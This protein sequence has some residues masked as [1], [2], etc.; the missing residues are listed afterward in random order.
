MKKPIA[1][2][3]LML[4]LAAGP[5][6]HAA[7]DG[8]MAPSDKTL[9]DLYWRGHESLKKADWQA[10]LE[11]F[12]TLEQEMRKKDPENADAAIYWQAYTL[13]QIKRTTEAR[14][15]VERLHRDFPK[16][17]WGKDADD[18]L[19]QSQAGV[20]VNASASA[21]ASAS[22]D[23]EDITAI[24]V[25]GLMNAPAQRALPLLKK[26]LQSNHSEKVK[27][28]ALFVLSQ[29]DEPTA[30]D[31][32]VDIAK[33]SNDPALR[34]EAVRMLGVSGEDRAVQRLGELYATSKDKSEKRAIIQAWLVA[35]REDLILSTARSEPDP[36]LRR[37]A[38]QTLGAMDAT[39]ALRQLFDADKD[40]ANR[41]AIV[42]AL[43][44]AGA[45]DVLGR[46]AASSEPEEL[47]IEAIRALGV[48]GDHGGTDALVRIY[49][50]ASSPAVRDAAL[51]GLLVAGDSHAVVDLY[52]KA[53]T[54]E[55][56]QALLRVLTTMDSD[57]ALQIIESELNR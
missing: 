36:E 14:A 13:V 5:A 26:V 27:K 12:R 33:S 48:A 11:R 51:Q 7:A 31:A 18:L 40:P 45:T 52:R 10:A 1:C 35:D 50:G 15:A 16:S 37:S 25:E 9:N 44:V 22:A 3:L 8:D 42:Q 38:I 49:A 53:K 57:D 43:G 24:A 4:A 17:R 34:E 41:K 2:A 6:A 55:E 32:L 39:D 56:K 23:D 30:L 46:I 29:I 21:S 47:R 28:R 20:T 54:K 19:R